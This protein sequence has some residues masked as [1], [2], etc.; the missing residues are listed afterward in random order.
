M[1]NYNTPKMWKI[2]LKNDAFAN[3]N[4]NYTEVSYRFF[5]PKEEWLNKPFDF[6]ANRIGSGQITQGELEK[7]IT[8]LKNV[9][10]GHKING[11]LLNRSRKGV[12]SSK[13]ISRE[14]EVNIKLIIEWDEKT[15]DTFDLTDKQN[16]D[17]IR[18]I[19]SFEHF[20]VDKINKEQKRSAERSIISFSKEDERFK[21]DEVRVFYGTNRAKTGNP[22]FENYFGGEIA[23]LS[24]G[25]CFINIPKKHEEGKIER[26]RNYYLFKQKENKDKHIIINDINEL[27][28]QDFYI[29]IIEQFEKIDDKSALIFIHGY[30]N[31]FAEAT[32]RAG[33]LAWDLPFNGTTAFFSWPSDGKTLS[34]LKDEVNARASVEHLKD[35]IEQLVIQTGVEKLH[36]IAHSMGNLICTQALNSLSQKQSFSSKIKVIDNIILAAPDIDQLDFKNNILPNFQKIGNRRTLYASRKDKALNISEKIRLGFPR[37]GDAGEQL[38][39]AN[40]LDTIDASQVKSWGNHHSYVFQI[41][42]VLTDLFYLFKDGFEPSKRRLKNS[43]KNNIDYW[44]FKE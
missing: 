33:Q 27:N 39:V 36:I 6:I 17:S 29:A 31:T 40:G 13:I 3:W 15:E 5:I 41:K 20:E 32:R 24:W 10:V 35:F 22:E 37:L 25:S 21:G 28:E 43:K 8:F 42:E 16:I 23:D 26:P 18:Y 30:N 4:E 38:F 12:I 34:Y 44:L 11:T 1:A 14:Y 9:E 19:S 2:E 7:L